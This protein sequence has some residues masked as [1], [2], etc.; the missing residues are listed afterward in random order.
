[1]VTMPEDKAEAEALVAKLKAGD[2]IN[3]NTRAFI[4][5][6]TAYN[7]NMGMY[8][9]GQIMVEMSRTGVYMPSFQFRN[10]PR[11]S[12]SFTNT[13]DIARI[14][15]E[16]IFLIYFY[17]KYLR[18][19]CKQMGE[20][21]EDPV[22]EDSVHWKAGDEKEQGIRKQLAEKLKDAK[23]TLGSVLVGNLDFKSKRAQRIVD[24]IQSV[25]DCVVI[26]PYFY[27][28][29]NYFDIGLIL[30]FTAAVVLQVVQLVQEMT[31]LPKICAGNAF[32]P[33]S[34]VISHMHSARMY[35]IAF[36]SFFCW[37]KVRRRAM[38]DGITAV[39]SV[40]TICC[41]DKLART[42]V[43]AYCMCRLNISNDPTLIS[44]DPHFSL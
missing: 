25:G 26:R 23:P 6:F 35:L 14:V 18:D 28:A 17:A 44:K 33:G 41:R 21:W 37:C 24:C 3:L 12:Y 22:K 32:V 34:F 9:V 11:V 4:V 15:L 31:A 2:W 16:A 27:E 10:F 19:E 43:V 38:G 30:C 7:A 20:Q 36:G 40:V 8:T 42:H 29:F 1:M 13:S 5:E 39:C